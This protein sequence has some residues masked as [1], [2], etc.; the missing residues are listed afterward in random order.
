MVSYGAVIGACEKGKELRRAFDVRA[1]MLRP[2]LLP[3]MVRYSGVISA[4]GEGQVTSA[5]QRSRAEPGLGQL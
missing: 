4:R 3:G 2:D 5:I 1:D